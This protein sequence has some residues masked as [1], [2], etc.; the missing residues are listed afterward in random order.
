MEEKKDGS[1]RKNSASEVA[2]HGGGRKLRAVGVV[3]IAGAVAPSRRL[4]RRGEFS[5][6]FSPH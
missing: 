1:R 3:S 2:P 6:E 5:K 4:R